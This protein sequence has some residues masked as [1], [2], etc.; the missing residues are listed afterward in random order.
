MKVLILTITSL[1]VSCAII[2]KDLVEE[3]KL[4]FTSGLKHTV[5]LGKGDAN[6]IMS[7]EDTQ[8]SIYMVGPREEFSGEITVIDGK[9][10][11]TRGEDDNINTYHGLT[12]L[13]FNVYTKCKEFKGTKI[14]KVESFSQLEGYLSGVSSTP[15]VFKF[16]AFVQKLKAHVVNGLDPETNRPAKKHFNIEKK[17]IVG[18]GFFSKNHRRIFTHHDSDVHIHILDQNKNTFHLD[19]FESLAFY[20]FE[21]CELNE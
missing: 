1:V 15:K 6:Y 18:L 5:R 17:N 9:V 21:Y 16:E 7:K 12:S 11:D 4:R 10:Y 8:K 3:K 13:V 2:K 19:D 14:K 20:Q